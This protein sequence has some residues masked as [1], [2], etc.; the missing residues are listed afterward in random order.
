MIYYQQN[1]IIVRR[2]QRSD[3]DYLKS[4]LRQSDVDEVMASNGHTPE[5]ALKLSLDKSIW[6][7]TV[8]NGHP[9]A[10]FGINPE[11]IL[12]SRAIVWMLASDDLKTIERRFIRN[13]KKF[14]KMM[15]EYYSYLYNYVDNRNE[16]SI[17]WLQYCGADIREPAPYGKA[18]LPFRYFS[19]N[20]S[21]VK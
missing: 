15:L 12:G 10:M 21:G 2:S 1:N 3:V 4:R 17:E 9:L 5:E 7:A 11:S 18:G 13:S 6:A 8:Q 20:R 16:K 14:I 19:F